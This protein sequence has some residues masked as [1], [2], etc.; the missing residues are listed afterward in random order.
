MNNKDKLKNIKVKLQFLFNKQNDI[1]KSKENINKSKNINNIH[2]V[3]YPKKKIKL[4]KIKKSILTIGLVTALLT[5]G[6]VKGV[7]NTFPKY[8]SITKTSNSYSTE[9]YIQN[10]DSNN[11]ISYFE[12]SVPYDIA[13]EKEVKQATYTNIEYDNEAYNVFKSFINEYQVNFPLLNEM[14]DIETAVDSIV[15]NHGSVTQHTYSGF[16]SNGVVDENK[17]LQSVVNNS[18]KYKEDNKKECLFYSVIEDTTKL[19]K[20]IHLIA[21]SLNEDIPSKSK[22]DIE[23][24]SCTLGGLR[25][26][27]SSGLSAA[28]ISN[29]NILTINEPMVEMLEIN[30]G[31]DKEGLKH[32][33]YHEAKHLEQVSCNDYKN[34]EYELQGVSIVRNNISND[35]SSS[36]KRTPL[37]WTWVNEGTAEEKSALLAGGNIETYANYIAY[38]ENLNISS[39]TS[40]YADKSY[41]IEDTTLNKD[42]N[43]FYN[44]LGM[45]DRITKKEIAE[46]MLSVEVFQSR[47][48]SFQDDYKEKFETELSEDD[49]SKIKYQLRRSYTLESSKIFYNNLAQ[50]IKNQNEV[51]LE[52]IFALITIFE[53]DLNYHFDYDY[54]NK[55]TDDEEDWEMFNEYKKIQDAFFSSLAMCNNLEYTEILN[56]FYNYGLYIENTNKEELNAPLT[57][58][59]EQKKEWLVAKS[60]NKRTSYGH[61][62][63]QLCESKTSNLE[64]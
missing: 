13:G 4:K 33:I 55:L 48:N 58:I 26:F 14:Y 15:T 31:N 38:I 51:K 1:E 9:E 43:K 6:C 41:V 47:F 50:A 29:N 8:N 64:K 56:K 60:N 17:L 37:D 63:S 16:I 46:M 34:E 2:I 54:Y 24:L 22:E 44:L 59:S 39:L 23:E 5:S 7:K 3:N 12:C 11:D 21:E 18:A 62:I 49:Y 25:I 20:I 27:Y 45:Q 57:W 10:V 61:Y 28:A 30:G 19:K 35:V 53:G 32:T 36:V 52:D 40:K 42:V